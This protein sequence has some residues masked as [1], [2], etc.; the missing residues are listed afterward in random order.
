MIPRDYTTFLKN[1]IQKYS[2]TLMRTK[3]YIIIYIQIYFEML[4]ISAKTVNIV[5]FTG[6]F[7]ASVSLSQCRYQLCSL[8]AR[9][10][11]RLLGTWAPIRKKLFMN[12]CL[13]VPSSEAALLEHFNQPVLCAKPKATRRLFTYYMNASMSQCGGRA[14]TFML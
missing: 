1:Y 5:Y 10:A 9:M 7:I 8:S 2:W 14:Q 3:T 4:P 12:C 11:R 13:E 6:V